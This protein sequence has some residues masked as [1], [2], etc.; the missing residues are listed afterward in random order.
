M[1]QATT[2]RSALFRDES[3]QAMTEYTLQIMVLFIGALVASKLVPQLVL[4]GL[5]EYLGLISRIFAL[6]IG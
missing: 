1:K 2:C 4:Q 6:P 5:Q 3:A